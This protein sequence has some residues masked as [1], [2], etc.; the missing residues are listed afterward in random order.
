[1]V[2]FRG[3]PFPEAFRP[4]LQRDIVCVPGHLGGHLGIARVS[5][6]PVSFIFLVFCPSSHLGE[7]LRYPSPHPG[8]P[9]SPRPMTVFIV[10]EPRLGSMSWAFITEFAVPDGKGG[11]GFWGFM[12]DFGALEVRLV[13]VR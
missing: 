11:F 3:I 5:W 2:L 4:I 8:S 9:G 7:F 10:L 13:F 6:N 1:V 12:I